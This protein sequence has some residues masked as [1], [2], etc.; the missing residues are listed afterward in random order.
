[1]FLCSGF[2]AAKNSQMLDPSVVKWLL[3]P[4]PIRLPP[5]AGHCTIKLQLEIS[6]QIKQVLV[7]K[8]GN[9]N[10]GKLQWSD[11]RSC[12]CQSL[13]SFTTKGCNPPTCFCPWH[14]EMDAFAVW[15]WYLSAFP[16]CV[17]QQKTLIWRAQITNQF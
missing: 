12:C 3:S 6:T 5:V 8:C 15:S 1:M 7:T 9:V 4:W 10:P 14:L 2:L 17:S 11:W 13:L 16:I